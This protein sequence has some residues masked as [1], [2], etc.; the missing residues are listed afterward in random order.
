M[1]RTNR[2]WS[3]DK[4]QKA[5]ILA[6]YMTNQEKLVLYKSIFRGCTDAY[7]YRWEK[8][9]KS[10]WAPAYIFN[11]DEFNSHR[12]RGGTI[13]DFENKTLIPLTDET[14]LNHLLGKESIGVYPILKNNTSYFIAA[15]FDEK[16]W[17]IDVGKVSEKCKEV[18]FKAYIEISRSGNGAHIWIF[19]ENEY[20]CFKSRAI[21]LELIRQAFDY[22]EFVKEISFDRLFPN[23]DSISGSGFG[24]LIAFPLQGER[25]KNNCSVFCDPKTFMPYPN[26]WEFLQQIRKHTTREIDKIYNQLFSKNKAISFVENNIEPFQ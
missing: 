1:D 26:Q 3:S 14:I 18:G 19:F 11:W 7:S 6:C 12:A 16:N 10:G 13:K 8:N 23:Q 9:E 21:M 25:V 17:Q 15:D 24:N 2:A 4:I 22:S 20:P 5:I